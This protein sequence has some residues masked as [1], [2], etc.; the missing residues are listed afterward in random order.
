MQIVFYLFLFRSVFALT[1]AGTEVDFLKIIFGPNVPEDWYDLYSVM[2]YLVFPF[3][4]VWMVL[5]GILEELRIFRRKSG[6][7]ALIALLISLTASAS[8]T[9]LYVVM[10][11]FTVMG[12]LGILAFFGVFVVGA[13]LWAWGNMRSSYVSSIEMYNKYKDEETAILEQMKKLND[14]YLQLMESARGGNKQAGATANKIA[15]DIRKWQARLDEVRKIYAA[16][17]S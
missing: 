13:S 12:W 16:R 5:Y 7:Q 11:T 8:G 14:N 9:L 10:G 2:Q 1:V 17:P 6:V 3:L 15:D 4:S